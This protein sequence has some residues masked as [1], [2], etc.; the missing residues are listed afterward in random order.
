MSINFVAAA[1]RIAAAASTAHQAATDNAQAI[2]NR[3]EAAQVRQAEI[4]ALRLAGNTTDSSEY[5]ALGGDIA[6]LQIM[7]QTATQAIE[8]ADPREAQ[9][10]LRAAEAEH[11]REQDEIA[12]SALSDRAAKIEEALL[13]CLGDLYKIGSRI[14]GPSLVMSWRPSVKLARACSPGVL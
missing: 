8:A 1:R 12:F 4:T 9:N 7:L 2:R 10:K 14:K 3:I 6:A 11:V 13:N 5:A